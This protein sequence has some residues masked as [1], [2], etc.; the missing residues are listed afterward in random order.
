MEMNESRP[1][2]HY[3]QMTSQEGLA[4]ERAYARR[5]EMVKEK[6]K[7]MVTN[8]TELMY[9]LDEKVAE[10]IAQIVSAYLG[11]NYEDVL[12]ESNLLCRLIIQRANKSADDLTPDVDDEAIQEGD[13]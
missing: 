9:L 1:L 8:P 6:A 12:G 4:V 2:P 5:R 7:E 10:Q 13:Q 11:H 3:S